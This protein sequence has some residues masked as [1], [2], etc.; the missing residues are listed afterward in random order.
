MTRPTF[1][2]ES[3]LTLVETMIAM[4]VVS[5]G[6]VAA[7]EM[8]SRAL[9][10]THSG[11][12]ENMVEANTRNALATMFDPIT[13]SKMAFVDTSTRTHY[14]VAGLI[15][16]SQES[17][18]FLVPGTT[19]RQ[20]PSATC[21]FHTTTSLLVDTLRYDCGFEYRNGSSL[22][23][24]ARGKVWPGSL[25]RCPLDG[26]VL[27]SAPRLDGVRLFI[28]RTSDG[29]LS[30]DASGRP[31]W[32]GMVIYFPY[33]TTDGLCELRRYDVY[34]SD[35]LSVP[36]TVTG[37]WTLFD[38]VSPTMVNLMDFGTD[39]TTNG[40]PDGSVPRTR[41]GSDAS[42]ELF[43][44]GTVNG[45]PSLVIYKSLGSSTSY[46]WRTLSLQINLA[47]GATTFL[48]QHY[49]SASLRWRAE[50]AF[51]RTPRTIVRQ[52]TEFAVSTSASSPW[53]SSTN[54]RGVSDPRVVRITVGSTARAEAES[55]QWQHHIESFSLMTRN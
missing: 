40:V 38:P 27:A 48:V 46:P 25:S 55:E 41:T 9:S 33:A 51:T 30:V 52:L 2:S 28:P 43:V 24:V 37:T 26:S 44:S 5:I 14:T 16:F 32:L 22:S 11:V 31:R 13:E 3:G 18:R 47:T 39:G 4:A 35:L 50:R 21:K 20:C 12:T 19:L 23:P 29:V 10:H 34:V 15:S 54:P 36:A 1:R 42:M 45:Q 8:F 7:S 53:S 6:F 17:D 49:Q